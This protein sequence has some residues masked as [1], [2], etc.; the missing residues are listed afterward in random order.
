[1]ATT[2]T[3][4]N[5]FE[6]EDLLQEKQQQVTELQ[7]LLKIKEDELATTRRQLNGF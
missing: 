4:L 5:E 1:M 6:R 2:R 7:D 3:Q